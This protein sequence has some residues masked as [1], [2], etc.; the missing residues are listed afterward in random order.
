MERI[1]VAVRARPLSPE[2]AKTS[3]WRITNNSIVFGTPPIKFDFGIVET[4]RSVRDLVASPFTARIRDYD[5]PDGLK[6]P[7]NLRTYD[8]T[9]DPDDYLTIFM[10][11]MDVHK[12]PEPAWCRFFHITLC[13]AARFWYD[14]LSSGS[15]NSF[16]SFGTTLI[17]DDEE[18]I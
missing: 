17:S 3:P 2:D 10:G 15:I 7:T 9:T 14:N 18:A 12:L 6:V 8:G 5:M 13:G 4:E 16:H 11:T 1:N